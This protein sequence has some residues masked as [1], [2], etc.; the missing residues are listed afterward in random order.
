MAPLGYGI[1]EHHIPTRLH[2]LELKK[3]NK[4]ASKSICYMLN[5]SVR[6]L[7]AISHLTLPCSPTAKIHTWLLNANLR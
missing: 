4:T 1:A 3:N 6:Y 2:L 7:S 5:A